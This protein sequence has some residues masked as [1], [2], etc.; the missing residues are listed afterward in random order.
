MFISIPIFFSIVKW[1]IV[2]HLAV[3]TFLNKKRSLRYVWFSTNPSILRPIELPAIE[4]NSCYCYS[5]SPPL[6]FLR[7]KQS[8]IALLIYIYYAFA[9]H[10][11]IPF[12]EFSC[13]A[14]THT[15]I[16]II[17]I[18]SIVLTPWRISVRRKGCYNNFFFLFLLT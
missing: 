4:V 8:F 15:N 17:C 13:A 2:V 16:Y 11:N 9:L 18:Y 3:A 6:S 5:T 7:S 14:S 12:A 10:S 1:M